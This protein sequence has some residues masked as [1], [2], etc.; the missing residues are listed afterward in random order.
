MLQARRSI[1][2]FMCICMLP[3]GEA[4]AQADGS[5]VCKLDAT[6]QAALRS[7]D[8]DEFLREVTAKCKR[9]DVVSYPS[10]H[11]YVVKKT[12]DFTQQVITTRNEIVC[13]FL[14]TQRADR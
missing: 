8:S 4:Y 10:S 2:G 12:C 6:F 14:G 1:I 3:I 7:V 9:G 13:I 5:A 11:T